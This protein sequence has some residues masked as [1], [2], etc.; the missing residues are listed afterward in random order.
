M[1][2]TKDLLQS[3]GYCKTIALTTP[4]NSIPKV[5]A[6]T[7]VLWHAN[8]SDRPE[9]YRPLEYNEIMALVKDSKAMKVFRE[10]HSKKLKY[11][12]IICEHTDE[13]KSRGFKNFF[14]VNWIGPNTEVLFGEIPTF[15]DY[16]PQNIE[17]EIIKLSGAYLYVPKD[18]KKAFFEPDPRPRRH[19]RR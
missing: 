19:S 17:E 10:K 16:N 15:A 1:S 7:K 11:S 12:I 2:E 8:E 14:L 3:N 6:I 5:C 9:G 18:P 13:E 4:N